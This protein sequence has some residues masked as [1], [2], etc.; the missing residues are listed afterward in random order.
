MRAAVERRSAWITAALAVI[1]LAAGGIYSAGL[2][3]QLRFLPDE[4][5]YLALAQN[6]AAGRG[7]TLDGVIPTAYRAPAYP[8]LLAAFTLLDAPPW[9]LR[10]VN[11]WLLAGTVT[12]AYA[13][14]HCRGD[15]LAGVLA[16]LIAALNP[17]AFFTAGTFYPQTLAGLL[18]LAALHLA[19]GGEPDL[20]SAALAGL[21]AGALTLTAPTFLVAMLILAA[22]LL[23]RRLW[24]GLVFLAMLGLVVGAWAGRNAAVMGGG[25]LLATNFGENLLLGNAPGARPNSGVNVDIT[26]ERAAAA[27]LSEVE[28]DRYFAAR[29]LEAMRTRPLETFGLYLAKTANYFNFRNELATAGESSTLRE[30]LAFLSYYPVLIL[31]GLRLLPRRQ[32]PLDV[33][34]RLLALLYVSN[35]L[36]AAV[37]F[38]RLRL[39]LPY[40]YLIALLAAGFLSAWITRH[41]GGAAGQTISRNR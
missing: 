7:F 37:F 29:A 16:A 3:G 12:L 8:A 31:A 5:D 15:R 33:Q 32:P 35:A 20:K 38:T 21:T 18:F 13:W 28:R 40:D 26:A 1:L 34:E 24:P 36:T 10:W 17:L 39:R 19:A 14:F 25:L 23:L 27:G 4:Q 30:A 2:G 11:Y 41:S 9:A 22:A 6:L